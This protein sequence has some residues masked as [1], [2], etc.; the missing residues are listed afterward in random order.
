MTTKKKILVKYDKILKRKIQTHGLS[1]HH[2]RILLDS[3]EE[4]VSRLGPDKQP[5]LCRGGREHN[6][7][8]D[9]Q[10]HRMPSILSGMTEARCPLL[11]PQHKQVRGSDE[12]RLTPGRQTVDLQR[13]LLQNRHRFIGVMHLEEGLTNVRASGDGAAPR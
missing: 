9:L 11:V 6:T 10:V 7:H 12:D 1:I 2:T 3:V 5:V 13:E 4:K 8:H